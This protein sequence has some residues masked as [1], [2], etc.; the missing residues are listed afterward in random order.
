MKD[1][2]SISSLADLAV[3]FNTNDKCKYYI[4]KYRWN[5]G[6]K[7]C[8]HCGCYKKIYNLSK[9]FQYKCG[10]CERLFSVTKG[11]IFEKSQLPLIKWFMAIWLINSAKKGMSSLQLART[12]GV[13]Q[14]T[15][16]LMYQK[17]REVYKD[18]CNDEPLD[19]IVEVDETFVGGLNKNRHSDKKV[20]NSQGRSFKDKVPIF[21]A[22]E[23][24]GRVI[25]EQVA[26]TSRKTL[27]PVIKRTIKKG[28]TVYSD[29]WKAYSNLNKD[30]KHAMVFHSSKQYADGDVTTNRI[31]SFWA[32]LKRAYKGSFHHISK[33]HMT[34]YIKEIQFRFNRRNEP[35][36]DMFK[37]VLWKCNLQVTYKSLIV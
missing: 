7:V 6:R 23:R 37:E 14:K 1:L 25:V 21:G 5:D 32:I 4:E 36:L 33:K 13:T 18:S 24:G 28:S 12:I 2:N 30:Y 29:E 22:I 10:D 11:T 31:E 27:E 19:G 26:N 8:P 3:T 15:A 9:K 34:R 17:I 20:K 16:W 35:L